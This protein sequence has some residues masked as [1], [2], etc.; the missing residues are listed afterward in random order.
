MVFAEVL[1]SDLGEF[2][3]GV[4]DEVAEDGFIVIADEDDFFD[5]G[6]FS[7]CSQAMPEDR[8]TGDIEQGLEGL[9]KEVPLDSALG[10]LTLG[11]SRDS[12]LNLVPLEGPPT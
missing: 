8:V 7:D 9:S 2:A 3:G 6:D 11:T 1:D 10:K 5:V 4:F 12:G